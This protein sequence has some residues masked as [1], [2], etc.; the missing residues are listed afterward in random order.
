MSSASSQVISSQASFAAVL[1]VVAEGVQHAL[2]VV[3]VLRQRQAAH[4]QATLRDGMVGVAFDVHHLAVLHGQVHAASHRMVPRRRPGARAAFDDAVTT[5]DH[6]FRHN[7]SSRPL[8][9]DPVYGSLACRLVG[10][11]LS[12]GSGGAQR[13][14]RRWC[15][16]GAV[17]CG[18]LVGRRLV[19]GRVRR[20]R[21]CGGCRRGLRRGRHA[22]GLRRGRGR[23]ARG[24]RRGRG[25]SARSRRL[26]H[27][28]YPV[29]RGLAEGAFRGKLACDAIDAFSARRAKTGGS[30]VSAGLKHMAAPF[31]LGLSLRDRNIPIGTTI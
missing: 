16:E 11:L 1:R 5:I 30:S 13:A 3:H 2:F 24:L 21:G 26:R 6:S 31:S 22:R 20:R 8:S 12:G 15:R 10:R 17:R 19:G 7:L 28:V 4:A 14:D 29:G 9:S 18:R 25:R 27:V 23:S